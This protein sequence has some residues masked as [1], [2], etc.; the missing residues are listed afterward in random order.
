MPNNGSDPQYARPARP[1]DVPMVVARPMSAPR[2]TWWP[3]VM[4]VL[5]VIF[6]AFGV[7]SGCC[8]SL[9]GQTALV[10]LPTEVDLG[11]LLSVGGTAPA[12]PIWGPI[13]SFLDWVLNGILLASGIGLA[14]RRLWGVRVTR[15]WAYLMIPYVVLVALVSL[16]DVR[17]MLADLPQ[18][19]GL[20]G[21][22]DPL[23]DLARRLMIV[24]ACCG[25]ALGLSSPLVM[26][27]WFSR[28]RIKA[29]I[30]TWR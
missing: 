7:L 8:C 19:G 2:R 1:R 18:G 28:G 15:L 25:I 9:A 22:V 17:Q 5:A 14:R 30:R 29:E 24:W 11:P 23:A 10:R 27:W 16:A 26:L 4:G 20:H 13:S 3:A 6:G 12:H 21:G